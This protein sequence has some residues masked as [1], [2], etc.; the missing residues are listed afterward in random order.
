M[1]SAAL[2]FIPLDEMEERGYGEYVKAFDQE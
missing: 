1:N 2:E